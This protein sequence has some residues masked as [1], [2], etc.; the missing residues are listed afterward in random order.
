MGRTENGLK[1]AEI[2][3]LSYRVESAGA[4]NGK[5]TQSP[6]VQLYRTLNWS[7]TQMTSAVCVSTATLVLI[8]K[9]LTGLSGSCGLASSLV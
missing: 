9:P 3:T 5:A 1:V 4:A 7:V 6:E 2:L 8:V